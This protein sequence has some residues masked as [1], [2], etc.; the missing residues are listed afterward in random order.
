MITKAIVQKNNGKQAE[1]RDLILETALQLFTDRG[2][3]NTSVHDIRKTADISIGSI[4]H[5][6]KNKEAI[7]KALYD[8]MVDR[9]AERVHDIREKH[10]TCQG[11]CRAL[12][13]S[14]FQ[15]ADDTP[16]VMKYILYAR[17]REFMPDEKSICSSRPFEMMKEIVEAGMS[18]GEIREMAPMVAATALF[19]GPIRLIH[20]LLDGVIDG[21]LITMLDETWECAWR[22]VRA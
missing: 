6:F 18:Q 10:Q 17:H 5:H 19:G 4:Y 7:A 12:I 20:L 14:F 8:D 2:Y 22:S 13:A 21:P 9:M 11:R 16:Q 3:F 1:M 15:C